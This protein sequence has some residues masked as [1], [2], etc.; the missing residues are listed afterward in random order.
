LDGANKIG[1]TTVA[2]NQDPGA[3]ADF[4]ITHF[5]DLLSIQ[6]MES[7]SEGQRI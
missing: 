2:F 3:K 6:F 5:N 4:S 7:S 1:M